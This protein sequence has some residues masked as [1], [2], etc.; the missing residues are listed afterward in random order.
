MIC[1]VIGFRYI[2]YSAPLNEQSMAVLGIFFGML[3]GWLLIDMVWPSLVG[4]I[5]LGCVGN[6]SIAGVFRDAFGNNTVLMLIFFCAVTS[7]INAAGVAE[8]VARKLVSLPIVRGRPYVLSFMLC[9]ATMVLCTMLSMIA[10][11]LI[12]FPLIKEVAKLYGYKPGDKW[13]ALMILGVH[14]VASIAYMMLPFK[15]VPGVVLGTYAQ[16]SGQSINYA[17]YVACVAAML[18]ASTVVLLTFYKYVVRPDVSHIQNN[19]VQLDCNITLSTYQK[20]VLWS[21]LVLITAL[22]L[23]NVAPK[24]WAITKVLATLSTNGILLLYIAIFLCANFRKGIGFKAIMTN[25]LAWPAIY[26]ATAAIAIAGAFMKT[27]VTEWVGLYSTPLLQGLSPYLF[28]FMI[29]VMCSVLTQISNN[30]A[31]ASMFAPLAYTLGISSGVDIQAIMLCVTLSATLGTVTPPASNTV[32]FIF[33]M[34]D[35]VPPRMTMSYGVIYVVFNI[36]LLMLVGY[37]MARILF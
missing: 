7:I 11:C 2:P 5:L 29:I 34:T 26:L 8:Y 28:V 4:L 32:A 31:T 3:Y 14:Y 9:V 10:A 6:A 16:M 12:A 21:F 27:G 33:G 25:E 1:I 18:L 19:D 17:S 24:S 23:P 22:L 37:N 35:W 36:T 13:P 30:I 15:S 20:C